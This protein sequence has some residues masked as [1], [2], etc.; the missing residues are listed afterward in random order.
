[1]MCVYATKPKRSLYT[2]T[3]SKPTQELTGREQKPSVGISYE[4]TNFLI[5]LFS[6]C[7]FF[8]VSD[9]HRNPFSS[10]DTQATG[11]RWLTLKEILNTQRKEGH[12][13]CALKLPAKVYINIFG[14]LLATT[15]N[16]PHCNPSAGT[17][18]PISRT[19]QSHPVCHTIPF[20][21]PQ[22]KPEYLWNCSSHTEVQYWLCDAGT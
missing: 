14:K 11:F 15:L 19:A 10:Q 18:L 12:A 21:Q 22:L 7:S 17:A 3:A 2:H 6:N 20:S 4:V 1:M 9:S 8:V 5:I 13:V 16:P